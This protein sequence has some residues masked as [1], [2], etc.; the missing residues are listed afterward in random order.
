MAAAPRLTADDRARI[1]A[2]WRSSGL[3]AARFASQAGV[4]AHTL[5]AWRRRARAEGGGCGVGGG[6]GRFAELVLRSSAGLP[7]TTPAT[8][9]IDAGIEIAVGD[10]VVRVGAVFDD[11]HLR[12]VLDVVRAMA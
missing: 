12:R 8:G 7:P 2:E 4:T 3:S 11:G 1:L 5:Y 9:Q 6:A 10:A